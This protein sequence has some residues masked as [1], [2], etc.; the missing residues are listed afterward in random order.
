LQ[1]TDNP[2]DIAISGNGF[3]NV[4]SA[5]G[6]Q[7]YTRN[8]DFLKDAQG[9]L[10]DPSG[11]YLRGAGGRIQIPS[12][13][14][15]GETTV[16][17]NIGSDGVVQAIGSQGTVQT[18]DTINLT[19]FP[20]NNGLTPLGGGLYG[21]GAG[22]GTPNTSAPGTNGNGSLVSGAL[23]VSNVDIA[24]EMVN[25]IIA[26]RSFEANVSTIH[27]TDAMLKELYSRT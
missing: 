18:V 15:A 27:T 17:F 12:S 4:E 13:V 24:E 22:A 3:F 19:N 8:G 20:N 6:S 7:F 25:M 11:D 2:S 23:E 14:G 26:Q 10:R 16:N 1:R 5:S 9:F 21:A